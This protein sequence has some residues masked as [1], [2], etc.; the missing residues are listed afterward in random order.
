M[1]LR[2]CWSNRQAPA[3]EFVALVLRPVATVEDWNATTT[4]RNARATA[5][6]FLRTRNPHDATAPGHPECDG[7]GQQASRRQPDLAQGAKDRRQRRPQYGLSHLA[8]VK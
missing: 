8:V 6:A 5:G 1:I 7:D 2:E 4:D 3:E